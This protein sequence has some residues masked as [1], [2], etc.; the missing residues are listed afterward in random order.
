MEWLLQAVQQ[1]KRRLRLE[2][3]LLLLLRTLAI[4]LLALA[5]Q[6]QFDLERIRCTHAG[7]TSGRSS[8][9]RSPARS[10]IRNVLFLFQ[11]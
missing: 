6:I 10:P 5:V 2:S 8:S 11:R 9:I 7:F 4:L 1:H 3:L